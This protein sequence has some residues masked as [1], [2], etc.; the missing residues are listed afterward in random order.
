MD[1]SFFL[2][3]QIF[4]SVANI[5][6]CRSR[7]SSVQGWSKMED[8]TM[9]TSGGSMSTAENS[10]QPMVTG[11]SPA[12]LDKGKSLAVSAMPSSTA[13][14]ATT[15]LKTDKCRSLETTGNAKGRF[16]EEIV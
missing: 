12:L 9:P 1:D 14:I 4:L 7:N 11:N 15:T 2:C 16:E 5:T 3:R 13:P 10:I 6:L 8:V